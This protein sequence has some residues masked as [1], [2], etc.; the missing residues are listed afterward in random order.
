MTERL[1]FFG[2]GNGGAT[3]WVSDGTTSGTNAIDPNVWVGAAGSELNLPVGTGPD[4]VNLYAGPVLL[5]ANNKIYAQSASGPNLLVCDTHGSTS[6]SDWTYHTIYGLSG[7]SGQLSPQGFAFNYSDSEPLVYFNGTLQ[8]SLGVTN[9]LFRTDGTQPGT[10]NKTTSNVNP[11]SFTIGPFGKLFFSGYGGTDDNGNPYNVVLAYDGSGQPGP[12]PWIDVGKP[13]FDP[14]Y[15]TLLLVPPQAP[16]ASLFMAGKDSTGTNRRTCLY[17][18]DSTNPPT[19]IDPTRSGLAPCNLVSFVDD[20][21]PPWKVNGFDVQGGQ[22]ILFFS[23]ENDDGNRGLWMSL[24]TKETTKEVAVRA[25]SG[26]V[27]WN[28]YPFNLTELN[29]NIYFTGQDQPDG[30]GRGLFVY[31]P[32]TTEAVEII[33]SGTTDLGGGFD[34]GWGGLT[35]PQ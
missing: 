17:Q 26:P 20:D 18:Y 24:G 33:D 5:Y 8:S 34:P 3:V 4:P 35:R 29:G 19:N 28:L 23:G 1:L 21:L 6:T 15:L 25:M 27:D 31:E 22:N 11:S 7:S 32:A 13:P 9:E 14:E 10:T 16:P 12:A 2:E 30:S